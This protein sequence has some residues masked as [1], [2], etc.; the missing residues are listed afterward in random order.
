M[1][2]EYKINIKIDEI[3]NQIIFLY[4]F[5]NIFEIIWHVKLLTNCSVGFNDENKL[6]NENFDLSMIFKN[7]IM[8]FVQSSKFRQSVEIIYT[9]FS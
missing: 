9:V 2:V 5:V 7:R 1:R 6:N 3:R 4:M 8:S